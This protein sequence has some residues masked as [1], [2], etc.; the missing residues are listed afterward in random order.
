MCGV[1]DLVERGDKL[2]E[3]VL[4]EADPHVEGVVRGSRTMKLPSTRDLSPGMLH[5]EV[6]PPLGHER[7]GDSKLG[8]PE[9]EHGRRPEHGGRTVDGQ[10]SS[11]KT[12]YTA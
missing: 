2:V 5:L 7:V 4:L 1:A 9:E 12:L 8:E 11:N 10:V 3:L 6:I